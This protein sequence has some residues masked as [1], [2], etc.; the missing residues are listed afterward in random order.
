MVYLRATGLNINTT[1][2]LIDVSNS[3]QGT[4]TIQYTTN[5][6][7]PN[8][9]SVTVNIIEAEDPSFSGN[10]IYCTDGTNPTATI[11]GTTGGNFSSSSTDLTVGLSTGTLSLNTAIAGN[12]M[13]Y[14]TTAGLCTATDSTSIEI[15]QKSDLSMFNG[16][17]T[18]CLNTALNP[19][20]SNLNLPNGTFVSTSTDL[21]ANTTIG[22]SIFSSMQVLTPY[23][24]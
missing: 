19:I 24:L 13:I 12:Y 17:T 3:A 6:V 21:V 22:E 14:Y 15:V 9:N 10:S 5:D 2:G 8:T 1:T 16:D 11:T 7:C 20:V 4:Y 18:L 23:N